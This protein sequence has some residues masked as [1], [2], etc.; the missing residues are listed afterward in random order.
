MA[1][2]GR[3]ALVKVAGTTVTM[4]AEATTLLS[5]A[6][7]TVNTQYQITATTKQIIDINSTI[8]VL[9]AAVPVTTGFTIDTLQ[10]IIIFDT[11]AIRTVTVTGK[12]VPTSTAAECK[13]WSNTINADMLDV[14]KFQDDWLVKQQGLKSCEGSLSRWLTIDTYFFDAL[15]AGLPV[16]IE[17]YAQDTLNPDRVWAILNSV[18][19][20]AAVDGALEEAVSFESTNKMLASYA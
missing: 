9:V 5:G 4:T 3:K 17:M 19:M 12:Y 1:Y 2:A 10:G 20:S 16:V 7:I 13:E 18:E 11:P 8:T 15:I 6:G 14:T